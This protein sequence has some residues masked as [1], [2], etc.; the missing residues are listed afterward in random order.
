MRDSAEIGAGIFIT[1][2]RLESTLLIN[3]S[4]ERKDNV[5]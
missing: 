3:T 2:S 5:L 1:Y 4:D